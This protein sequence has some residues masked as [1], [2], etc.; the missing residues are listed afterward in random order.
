MPESEST[1]VQLINVG[2]IEEQMGITGSGGVVKPLPQ[3]YSEMAVVYMA[4][5]A[6]IAGIA[7]TLIFFLEWMWMAHTSQPSIAID[8]KSADL[9]TLKQIV[10]LNKSLSDLY[11]DRSIKLFDS[12]IGKALLPV[13][14]TLLG[15]IIGS[16]VGKNK[17]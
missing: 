17:E 7:F 6:G 11:T 4:Y 14:S 15:F 8:P 12:F 1:R 9:A 3:T 10:E 5:T 13:L 2:D 16:K